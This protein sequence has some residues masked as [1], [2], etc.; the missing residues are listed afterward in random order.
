[1][2]RVK[3]CGLTRLEDAL[4]AA[5]SGAD[6]LGFVFYPQSPRCVKPA[7]VAE[8]VRRLPPYVT[9][10]GVF[11]NQPE[12]EVRRIVEA[13]GLDL[14]QLQGDEPPDYC[15]EFGARAV[16]AIRVIDRES[17][18]RIPDYLAAGVRGFVLDTYRPGQFGGT[19]HSFD[20]AIAEEAVSY[21]RM[22]LAGGL[23]PEN[24]REAVRRVQP[25]GVDV[26]SGVELRVGKK[27]PEK[28]QDFI[29]KAREA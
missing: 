25:Y 24:V 21:G 1:V 2:I 6:A 23:T 16:K 8:I 13:C 5:E 3:I 29:R 26:S 18:K 27:D 11:A 4:V 10:V 9:A 28:V 17:L 7:A 14:V 20:W 22:I 12:P 15:R 19:G